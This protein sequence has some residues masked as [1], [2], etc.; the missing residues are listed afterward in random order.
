MQRIDDMANSN[1][2]NEL[3]HGSYILFIYTVP[4]PC[5]LNLVAT[6]LSFLRTFGP[7]TREGTCYCHE[8]IPVFWVGRIR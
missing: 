4:S 3:S 2:A 6:S 5:Q 7:F 8:N 1:H